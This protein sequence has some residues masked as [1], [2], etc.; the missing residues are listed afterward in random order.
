MTLT[1][2][3]SDAVKDCQKGIH[4]IPLPSAVGIS[5]SSIEASCTCSKVKIKS[6]T[7]VGDLSLWRLA[8]R[9]MQS[10]L[11][12]L[13]IQVVQQRNAK[14]ADCRRPPLHVQKPYN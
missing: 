1:A 4:C 12:F 2:T 7:L 8:E 5:S 10:L 13:K 3:W 9:Q 14:M 6:P 11:S